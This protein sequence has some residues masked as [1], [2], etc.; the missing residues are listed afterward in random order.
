MTKVVFHTATTIN[1]F[2][3]TEDDS[4]Q[5]LF[6]VP[7]EGLE[8]GDLTQFMPG[9]GAIVTGSSTYNWVVDFENL[10]EHPEKGQP[11]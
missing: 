7:T 2:L 1:G 5:W 4:L 9:V 11:F 6:D 3:A 10:M 8:D